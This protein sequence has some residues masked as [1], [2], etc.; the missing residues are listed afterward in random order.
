MA[1]RTPDG[2]LLPTPPA[3]GTVKLRW[4]LRRAESDNLPWETATVV[5]VAGRGEVAVPE[6]RNF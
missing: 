6:I 2:E 3:E 1:A 5:F 4:R